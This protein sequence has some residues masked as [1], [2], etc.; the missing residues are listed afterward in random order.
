[1]TLNLDSPNGLAI[2]Y[3]TNTAVLENREM[4]LI[5]AGCELEYVHH[6]WN[7]LAL[8]ECQVVMLLT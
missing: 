6:C 5:D 4:V 3:T 7:D 8:T 2:H 1:M